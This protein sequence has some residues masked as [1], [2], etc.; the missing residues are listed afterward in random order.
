MPG[1]LG[2]K[3]G[4]GATADVH[5]WAPGQV[6]KLF[7]LGVPRRVKT[8]EAR[9]TRAV[10]L[11]GA[12]APEVFDEV[13]IGDR[14]G[15]VMAR[16]EG[17]TLLQLTKTGAISYAEAGAILADILVPVHA[18]P[19][20]P[21][22]PFLRDYIERSV[23]HAGDVLSD[24]VAA[25]ILALTDRLS[26]GD[27]LCHGDPNPGNVVMTADG[28]KLIDWT[29]ALRAP[30]LFDLA[31]AHVMLTELAPR[32]A[33]DPERPRAI[34]AAMHAAYARLAGASPATLA[35]SVKPYL[36]VVRALVLLG[37]AVPSQ[38]ASLVARLCTDFPA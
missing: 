21:E 24:H 6:V 3:I 20:P 2:A 1:S 17:P 18:T 7:K 38:T 14:F 30:P 15:F 29:A 8:H 11:S 25:G 35:S 37:G 9:I 12:P 28:P 27:G 5:E 36:P 34:Y 22:I 10:F 26:L 31:S 32:V 4:E 16:L 33:D 23:T 13:G 19:P